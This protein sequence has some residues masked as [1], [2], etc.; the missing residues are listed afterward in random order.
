MKDAIHHMKWVQRKVI[1]SS[2]KSTNEVRSFSRANNG[3]SSV[4][5]TK[6]NGVEK[7]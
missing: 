2:K 7:T 4:E 1:Q 5:K 3:I 6:I